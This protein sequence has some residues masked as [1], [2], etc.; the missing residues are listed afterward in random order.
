MS[1]T[2]EPLV[3][4]HLFANDS[5]QILLTRM[6]YLDRQEHLQKM[7]RSLVPDITHPPNIT[8]DKNMFDHLLVDEKHRLLYC[9]VP[10]VACTNWKRVFMILTGLVNTSDPLKIPASVA[11]RKDIITRLSNYSSTEIENI[12][13][14][15]TKFLFVR[16]PFERLLSA[17]HNKLE[18]HYQ[19]SKYFQSRFGRLIIKHY[20]QNPSNESLTRGDDVTFKE[21]AAYLTGQKEIVFNEHWKPIYDL[22][23]PC[24]ISYDIIGKYETLDQDSEFILKQVGETGISFPHAP[25]SSSTTS[26]LRKYFGTLHHDII[27]QLYDVYEMDFK[28][29]GYNLEEFLGYETG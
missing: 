22:C 13:Q 15:F 10:K 20:R 4:R 28:L 17:Y 5:D 21:F 25:K 7:C 23:H 16:H 27:R 18:Q 1:R 6:V 9:Y 8:N 19:S 2:L 12:L 3:Y 11:H 14:S 26:N 29:F 24:T